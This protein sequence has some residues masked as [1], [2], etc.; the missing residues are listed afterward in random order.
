MSESFHPDDGEGNGA[1]TSQESLEASPAPAVAAP[2][3][4]E[5]ASLLYL[6]FIFHTPG[7]FG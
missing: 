6:S 3:G 1:S 4:N 2:E 5:Q 7:A